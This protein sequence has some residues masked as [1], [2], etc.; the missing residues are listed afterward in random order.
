M[1]TADRI[2][3]NISRLLPSGYLNHIRMQLSYAGIEDQDEN[4]Y[5]G[6]SMLLAIMCPIISIVLGP[7]LGDGIVW[8]YIL[9][10]LTGG[11]LV[12]VV[13]YLLIYFQATDRARRAEDALP[14]ALHLIAANMRA[15]MTP[16]SALKTAQRKELGPL[17]IEITRA[18]QR[19]FGTESFSAV[20]LRV[21]ERL[22]SE[23]VDRTLRLFAASLASGGH[24]AMLLEELARDIIETR[25]LKK[26]FMAATKTYSLFIFFTV[27]IGAP[28]LLNI[29][30]QFVRMISAIS[31]KTKLGSSAALGSSF[32]S[33]EL[34]VTVDFLFW[35]AISMLIITSILAS[36]LMSVIKEGR[37]KDGFR[38]APLI[39][40]AAI[41][42]FF[43]A[44]NLMQSFF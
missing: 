17:A 10:G 2:Y 11:I 9:L 38:T 3:L 39:A 5:I 8:W 18:T 44:G 23:T 35:L 31:A 27:V 34:P 40:A 6:M 30:I 43:I 36:M 41:T 1:R 19:A 33:G 26:E 29:S 37:I 4:L 13:F 42:V 28:F 7:A 24:S 21:R 22:N 16:F 25:Q 12:E 20:L 14:D 32:F 15:G